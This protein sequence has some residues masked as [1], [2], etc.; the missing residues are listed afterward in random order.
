MM[1]KQSDAAARGARI[2]DV[3]LTLDELR[4]VTLFN[5]SCAD[6]VL[7][8]FESARPGDLRPRDAIERARAFAAGGPRAGAQRA[9]AAAAHRAAKEVDPPAAHAAMAAGDA[10]AS[11][12]LH[13]LADPTQVGHILR[14]PAHTVLAQEPDRPPRSARVGAVAT[15]LDLATPVV[16]EVLRCYPSPARR[17]QGVSAVMSDLDEALRATH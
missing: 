8:L 14:G 6:L 11:S 3:E 17:G 15:V 7:H 4:A 13:P 12:Y 2:R 9:A 5:L 1:P 10:A 16:V